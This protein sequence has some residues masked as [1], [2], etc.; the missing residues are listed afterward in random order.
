MEEFPIPNQNNRNQVSPEKLF[1]DIVSDL[2]SLCMTLDTLCLR[3]HGLREAM[4]KF[5]H[6]PGTIPHPVNVLGLYELATECHSLEYQIGKYLQA[7]STYDKSRAELI[8]NE[9][10]VQGVEWLT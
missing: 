3:Y 7:I 8:M 10:R 5:A 4:K 1:L 6:I 9:L 2:E